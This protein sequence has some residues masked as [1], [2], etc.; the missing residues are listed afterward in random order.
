MPNDNRSILARGLARFAGPKAIASK[1]NSRQSRL[2]TGKT[3]GMFDII[4]RKKKERE[5]RTQDAYAE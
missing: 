1:M 4:Y 2:G 5:A 3:G